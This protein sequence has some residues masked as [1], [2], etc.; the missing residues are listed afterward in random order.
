MRVSVPQPDKLKLVIDIT[1]EIYGPK[2]PA[3]LALAQWVEHTGG[4]LKN[5]PFNSQHIKNKYFHIPEPWYHSV[6]MGMGKREANVHFEFKRGT[7]K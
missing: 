3:N 2:A 5:Q 1:P 4:Y 7:K 6:E